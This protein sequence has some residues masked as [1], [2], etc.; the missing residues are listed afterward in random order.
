MDAACNKKSEK[1]DIY[2]FTGWY[3]QGDV[4]IDGNIISNRFI[5]IFEMLVKS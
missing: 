1:R 4:G 3:H 2:N 5:L